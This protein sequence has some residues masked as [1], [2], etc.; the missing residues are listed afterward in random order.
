MP[1]LKTPAG[2]PA[3][4]LIVDDVFPNRALLAKG[5]QRRGWTT[6]TAE[7]GVEALRMLRDGLA[8]EDDGAVVDVVLLDHEMPGM[9]GSEVAR[10]MRRSPTLQ[11]IPIIGLTGN[12]L[13]EDRKR[14]QRA[15]AADVLIKP[16]E[17]ERVDAY[18]RDL[19][20]S[21]AV[22]E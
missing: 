12:A 19:L 13:E 6:Q 9:N 21:T 15:G 17:V 11:H 10:E 5:L 18:L 22:A 3:V 20:A 2:K 14:F 4:V 7:G 1:Q 16:I 8:S